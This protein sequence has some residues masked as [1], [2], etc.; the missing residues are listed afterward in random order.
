MPSQERKP[1]LEYVEKTKE[2]PPKPLVVNALRF[3]EH[4]DEALDLGAG[5]LN[6]S[7]YLLEQDFKHVTAVDQENIAP[8]I[9][10]GLSEKKFTYFTSGFDNFS[11]SPDTFDFISA[12]YSLPFS[13]A[14]DDL[15]AK[16][17]KAL[18]PG[19]IFTGQFFGIKDEW[20]KTGSGM[21]F[22]SREHI[23]ELFLGLEVLELREEEKDEAPVIGKIKHW[24]IFH[25]I[26]RKK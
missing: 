8:E 17:I 6:N 19:G 7:K 14:L 16:I 24:H 10:G 12:Q 21:S 26:V 13:T 25:F 1:W 9:A 23:E 5:A 3:V 22:V 20:N 2:R 18:K 4:R 15:V 11:F